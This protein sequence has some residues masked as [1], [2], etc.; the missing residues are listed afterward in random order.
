[1]LINLTLGLVF[2][3][4][5]KDRLASDG[6][7][8]SPIFAF[9]GTFTGVVFVPMALYFLLVHPAWSF[10]YVIDP[11]TLPT[12]SFLP[13]VLIQAGCIFLGWFVG[14][15][16]VSRSHPVWI[17]R[18][19]AGFA[20]AITVL[21]WVWRTRL[22]AYGE[23]GVFHAGSSLSLFQVKLGYAAV[24]LITAFGVGAGITCYELKRDSLRVT[25]NSKPK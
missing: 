5:A 25:G 23:Y 10:L 6:P 15:Q 8:S 9:V 24:I 13:I 1:M 22:Y 14:S 21:L 2:S 3:A 16:L 20:L 18:V 11:T 12:F 17:W 4:F 19:V 7:L